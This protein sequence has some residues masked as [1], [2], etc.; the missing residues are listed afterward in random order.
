MQS[1]CQMHYQVIPTFN[2]LGK[3]IQ[4]FASGV[5]DYWPQPLLSQAF[6]CQRDQSWS[7]NSGAQ[8]RLIE[9]FETS[10]QK[11]RPPVYFENVKDHSVASIIRHD[12]QLDKQTD[13]CNLG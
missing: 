12:Y 2:F 6:Q 3:R 9:R 1:S 5:T 13:C 4:K 10:Q 7:R 8:T 11:P